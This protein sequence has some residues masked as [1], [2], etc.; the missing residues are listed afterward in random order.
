MPSAVKRCCR[1]ILSV[2]AVAGLYSTLMPPVFL[3]PTTTII[4]PPSSPK[5]IR[6][7]SYSSPA[8]RLTRGC[9]GRN[10]V[11]RVNKGKVELEYNDYYNIIIDRLSELTKKNHAGTNR[12]ISADNL[13][14]ASKEL[15]CKE[16]V[17]TGV[18]E[19]RKNTID[20]IAKYLTSKQDESNYEKEGLIHKLTTI[21]NKNGD[22]RMKISSTHHKYKPM[23]LLLDWDLILQWG[24]V[25]ITNIP[26][27]R[28]PRSN[29]TL[30]R[31]HSMTLM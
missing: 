25:T 18:E 30:E 1:V 22:R 7:R 12:L 29:S 31:E 13:N 23:I 19:D 17:V 16:C 5:S 28:D 21:L 6:N 2:L 20:V 24:A 9:T 15:L 26:Y 14:T 27:R 4:S 10:T 11:G 8:D 3:R